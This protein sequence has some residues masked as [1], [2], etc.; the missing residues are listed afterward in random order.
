MKKAMSD[1]PRVRVAWSGEY[2]ALCFGEWTLIVDGRDCSSL[3]PF[4]ESC[5]NTLGEY[6][7][8]RFD[9]DFLEVFEAY[10]DGL[11]EDEWIAENKDWLSK[12]TD[13]QALMREIF[14][15]FQASDFRYG[16]CGGCI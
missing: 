15:E 7:E 4:R 12:I 2:P 14:R 13:D 1:G 16:I 9:E 5:A 6:D 8:W 10:E 3:I 11:P